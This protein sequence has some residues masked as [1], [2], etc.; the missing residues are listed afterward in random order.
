M[1][2]LASRHA[3]ANAISPEEILRLAF[4]RDASLGKD[5]RRLAYSVMQG[6]DVTFEDREWVVVTDLAA[7]DEADRIYLDAAHP[8]WSPSGEQL[9]LV[10]VEGERNLLIIHENEV[11]HIVELP[12][13]I[14]EPPAWSP[15]GRF[16]A[17]VVAS[18]SGAE[19]DVR[20]ICSRE[21]RTDGLGFVSGR[22]QTIW[23]V[24]IAQASARALTE[25]SQFSAQPEW[26]PSGTCLLIM[27]T[28][29]PIGGSSYSPLPCIVD[30]ETG[31][32]THLLN[33]DWHVR[34][35]RWLPD[36]RSVA[37]AGAYQSAVTVPPLDIWTL[38]LITH[39]TRCRSHAMRA[40][41]GCRVHHD[42]PLWG[43]PWVDA[44]IAL[45]DGSIL[46]PVQNGGKP[47][48]WRF[49]S[50]ETVAPHAV[51]ELAGGA[52]LLCADQSGNSIAYL[53]GDMLSPPNLFVFQDGAS[54]RVAALNDTG[55][56]DWPSLK[57]EHLQFASAD[58]MALEGWH[59]C[60]ADAIR[61]LPTIMFV[62]GGPFLA[63]G[64]MFRFDHVMLASHGYGVLAVNFRGSYG[65]GEEFAQAIVGNWGQK[66]FPDHM[67]AIDHAIALNLADPDHI[68]VW[69]ASHGGYATCWIVSH[70]NRFRAAV[71]EAAVT[72]L[73]TAYYLSDS[74][75]FF[76]RDLGGKPHEIP[77]AYAAASPL[78]Y[79]PACT[80]PTL[81]LHG[82][83]DFRCPISEAEQFFRALLDTGCTTELVRLRDA[84]H[85]G[86]SVGPPMM[87]VAQ[88]RALLDWFDRYL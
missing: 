78:T 31:A 24:D 32:Q 66:G 11:Q 68:G 88:N 38:D 15:D 79:A 63:T 2:E 53:L 80:T 67:A 8:R 21:F 34:S 70:T 1:D 7:E 42:M 30:A 44:L 12:G 45:V 52:N 74:P 81:L 65:Y 4:V 50:D 22:K 55:T 33:D 3:K 56:A 77:E 29:H 57:V 48:I 71:A 6:N 76:A 5:G 43:A 13:S 37:F 73:A 86:D 40:R 61:P 47:E 83:K 46:A 17:V 18:D 69:G 25:P 9:A 36:G 14:V 16:V 27:A 39:Q 75:D 60:R 82:E 64:H 23:I 72:N 35:A 62:H 84:D 54:R 85:M 28:A 10:G 49:P 58:D 20:R 87:R 41:I 59:I 19:P 26:D 51:L